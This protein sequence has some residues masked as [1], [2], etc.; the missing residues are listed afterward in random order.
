MRWM[1]QVAVDI[2]PNVVVLLSFFMVSY[3]TAGQTVITVE[4]DECTTGPVKTIVSVPVD[5]KISASGYEELALRSR[6]V[7][8][9]VFLHECLTGRVNKDRPWLEEGALLN[10]W[11]RTF[12]SICYSGKVFH[13]KESSDEDRL[14]FHVEFPANQASIEQQWP[15]SL[16]EK[17]RARVLLIMS[18]IIHTAG[19]SS[20]IYSSRGHTPHALLNDIKKSMEASGFQVN[21][22]IYVKKREL[23]DR[24]LTSGKNKAW[25]EIFPR[26]VLASYDL[27]LSGEMEVFRENKIDTAD[28]E[29]KTITIITRMEM[30]SLLGEA[31]PGSRLFWEKRVES[32]P[33]GDLNTLLYRQWMGECGSDRCDSPRSDS[34][35]AEIRENW[36]KMN[37][38]NPPLFR[39]KIEPCKKTYTDNGS[40]PEEEWQ[41]EQMERWQEFLEC[42][43]G[44]NAAITENK[45]TDS[46]ANQ[47]FSLSVNYHGSALDLAEV[48]NHHRFICRP[49]KKIVENCGEYESQRMTG[50]LVYIRSRK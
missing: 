32:T 21:T 39:L 2:Y 44:M 42:S 17:S 10:R 23:P 35:I 9:R 49:Y 26:N 46:T 20:T 38:E 25:E 43:G 22:R 34:L 24:F 8:C 37:E 47:D 30:T 16:R 14:D 29:N 7:A 36:I 31:L 12:E 28:D 40:I 1:R 41:E 33:G 48:L 50:S 15:D 18:E 45:E 27:I 3:C 13:D 4:S 11:D 5:N 6:E 19:G